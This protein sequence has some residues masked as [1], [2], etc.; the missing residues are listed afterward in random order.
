MHRFDKH[1]QSYIFT[2]MTVAA[3]LIT[4]CGSTAETE[5]SSVL[6]EAA[7]AAASSNTSEASSVSSSEVSSD[8]GSSL[9]SA[10]DFLSNE[11][12]TNPDDR[13]HRMAK[14]SRSGRTLELLDP[15]TAM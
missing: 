7:S 8:A 12:H 6:S 11:V 3:I 13:P 4:G 5:S 14:R 9:E 15:R 2:A 1:K 10:E